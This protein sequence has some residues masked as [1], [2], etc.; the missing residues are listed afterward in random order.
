MAETHIINIRELPGR[1]LR[2]RVRVFLEG[3]EVSVEDSDGQ[4]YDVSICRNK[5]LIEPHQN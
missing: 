1:R 5:L 3:E 4:G 2:K